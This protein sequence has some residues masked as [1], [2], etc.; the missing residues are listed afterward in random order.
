MPVYNASAFLG[1]TIESVLS[2]TRA[3]LEV[4]VVDDLSTDD[5]V[6]VA[7]RFPVTVLTPGRK[8]WTGGART[9]GLRAARGDYYAVIDADDVWLP[10]HLERVASMLDAH[11]DAVCAF[12][13]AEQF[14]S[15]SGVLFPIFAPGQVMDAPPIAMRRIP[16]T[17]STA[18]GRRAAMLACGGYPE[19]EVRHWADDYDLMLR[20]SA[21]GGFICTH[22]VTARYRIHAQ[23]MSRSE[24]LQC[25]DAY[26]SRATFLEAVRASGSRE[27]FLELEAVL[28]ATFWKDVRDAID[29]TQDKVLHALARAASAY[30]I[31]NR[32][33]VAGIHLTAAAIATTRRIRRR[34][35]GR[36]ASAA[37]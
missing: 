22:D 37:Q 33:A 16:A 15:A 2:Q 4:L 24:H 21:F 17:H 32:A 13:A 9:H 28:R 30:S 7:R 14:G 36:T 18:I 25:A 5:S 29:W 6:A 23:Q 35:T 11:P 8:L 12:S 20:L 26:Q 1:E 34:A 31:A 27:R 3:P 19:G 10:H